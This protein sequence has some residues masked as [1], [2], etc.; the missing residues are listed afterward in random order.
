MRRLSSGVR[1]RRT[2]GRLQTRQRGDEQ[3]RIESGEHLRQAW[4][5]AGRRMSW[6]REPNVTRAEKLVGLRCGQDDDVVE[7]W[8][9]GFGDGSRRRVL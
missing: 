4:R 1:G 6:E 7:R 8:D 9:N 5:S 3:I 2:A